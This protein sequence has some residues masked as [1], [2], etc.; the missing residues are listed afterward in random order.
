MQFLTQ[1]L[2]FTAL[3]TPLASASCYSGG[4]RPS[5]ADRRDVAGRLAQICREHFV[6]D[7][8]SGTPKRFCLDTDAN[9]WNVNIHLIQGV[10]RH[11]PIDECISGLIKEVQGCEFG[12]E[13]KYT[14]W[15]YK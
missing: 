5:D 6:G 2:F 15:F 8:I 1:L 12:G 13:T 4:H 9:R 14:N 7:I 11:L 3:L 10:S